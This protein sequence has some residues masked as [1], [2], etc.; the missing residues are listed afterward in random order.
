MKSRPE[1][2]FTRP[3][4]APPPRFRPARVPVMAEGPRP[5]R[6]DGPAAVPPWPVSPRGPASRAWPAVLALLVSILAARAP[7]LASEVRVAGDFRVQ[8]VVFDHQNFTGQDPAGIGTTSIEAISQRLRLRLDF[9]ANESLSFRLGLRLNNNVWGQAPLVAANP[10]P[11]IQPYQAYLRFTVPDTDL[12][13]TAGYQPLAMPHSPV[14]YDSVVLSTDSGN[15]D[16]AALVLAAPLVPDLMTVRLGYGRLV[17]ADR[18]YDPTTTQ[19]GDECDLAFATMTLTRPGLTLTP[20]AAAGI[21]GRSAGDMGGMAVNLRSAGS[22]LDPRGYAD[23]QNVALWAG[24]TLTADLAPRL[25]V[26]ADLA[27]GQAALADREKNR[28]QGLFADLALEY[29]G[30]DRLTPQLFAWWSSGEDARLG[31]GSERLPYLVTTWGPRR[32][33]LFASDQL[34]YAD[35]LNVNPQGAMGLSLGLDNVRLLDRLTSL[36]G[37]TAVAGTNSPAGLRKAA[38]ATGGPG[39]YVQMGRDLAQGERLVSAYFNH[40][41]AL[42]EVLDLILETGWARGL[43][44][45][46]SIWGRRLVD[47]AGDVWCAGLG[48][49]YSF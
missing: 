20:W 22:Y 30:L 13:V 48:I 46:R 29:T 9:E 19:V 35:Y 17:D 31:N 24:A 33:F 43:D 23:N 14:F 5:D 12:S 8:A 40:A 34:L 11:A 15:I 45:R 2:G 41:Y 32:S 7:A 1:A 10:A 25:R 38:A 27:I 44:F 42:T 6:N 18:T 37:L 47:K 3:G 28:R 4:S 36:A 39:G 26:H 16:T 49:I 21:I